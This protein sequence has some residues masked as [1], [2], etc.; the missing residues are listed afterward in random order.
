MPACCQQ[1]HV[2]SL[3]TMCLISSPRPGAAS[4]GRLSAR[5]ICGEV[6]CLWPGGAGCSRLTPA[7]PGPGRP[8]LSDSVSKHS[9]YVMLVLSSK[10]QCFVVVVTLC[11]D[12]GATPTADRRRPPTPP[13]AA[14]RIPATLLDCLYESRLF[15][16]WNRVF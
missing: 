3:C 9:K 13:P 7:T 6:A 4:G 2:G 15:M 12:I 5:R 14:D 16:I 10:L 1:F 8:F 11:F